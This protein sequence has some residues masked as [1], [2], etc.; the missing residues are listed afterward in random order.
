[1]TELEVEEDGKV[2]DKVKESSD[3]EDINFLSDYI[4]YLSLG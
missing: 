2:D 4:F 3:L 1:M